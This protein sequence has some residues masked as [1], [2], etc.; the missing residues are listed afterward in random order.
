[1]FYFR[2][3]LNDFLFVLMSNDLIISNGTSCLKMEI[4]IDNLKELVF[5]NV[6]KS[7]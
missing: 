4:L 2:L 3:K 1:M 5:Q 6:Y 7:Y